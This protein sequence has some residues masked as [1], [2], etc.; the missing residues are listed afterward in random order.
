M[1][2]IVVGRFT[3]EGETSFI[4]T[5]PWRPGGDP[6]F[7]FPDAIARPDGRSGFECVIR[8]DFRGRGALRRGS[9]CHSDA[10]GNRFYGSHAGFY[11]L[12]A[13]PR[14]RLR[15]GSPDFGQTRSSRTCVRQKTIHHLNPSYDRDDDVVCRRYDKKC[16][17]NQLR[18]SSLTSSL[19]PRASPGC[20]A[21]VTSGRT[22]SHTTGT[23]GYAAVAKP[24]KSL[25][26]T[27]HASRHKAPLATPDE[28]GRV[29]RGRTGARSFSDQV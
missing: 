8:G 15:E 10:D 23:A 16:A 22:G 11:P 14:R 28:K 3:N 4:V 5:G 26:N 2:F 12:R 7:S 25:L 19:H 27:T 20:Y 29:L 9:G 17:T 21:G 1:A 18:F 13:H 6:P 24:P